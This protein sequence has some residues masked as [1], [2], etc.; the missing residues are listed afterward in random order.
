[1]L[2]CLSVLLRKYE[3]GNLILLFSAWRISIE[4]ILFAGQ[5]ESKIGGKL[6]ACLSRVVASALF[7]LFFYAAFPRIALLLR[8][9]KARVNYSSSL[10]A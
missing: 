4:E 9:E 7:S 3:F 5:S 6:C 8:K 10:P 1:M 2:K